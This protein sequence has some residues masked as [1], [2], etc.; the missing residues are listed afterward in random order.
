MSTQSLKPGQSVGNSDDVEYAAYAARVNARLFA[1]AHGNS[2]FT[3]DSEGLFGVYL[4]AFPDSERQFHNC[5]ACRRFI[6]RF[7]GLVTFGENGQTVSA[8]WSVDEAPDL[9]AP[10]IEAMRRVILRAKITGVFL[11]KESTYGQPLTGQW[12]HFFAKPDAASVFRHLVLS[13]D[14]AMA[15]KREDYINVSRALGEFTEPMLRQA[16]VLL[17][18]D[19]LY[20][21]EKV[22]GPAEWLHALHLQRDAVKGSGPRSN[23]VWRAVASAPAGF[24]HPRSSMV[25]TLLEDIAAGMDFESASR[26][27]AAKMHPLQYQRPQAAPSAGNI[28]QAEKIIAKMKAEGSLDRRFAKLEE[29]QAIWKPESIKPNIP[30]GGGV[31]GHLKSKAAS[32]ASMVLPEQVLTW[33]KFARSVVPDAANIEFMT[34]AAGNFS[35]LLTAMNPLAPPIIQWDR[36]NARNPVSWYLYHGGSSPESWHLQRSAWIKVNA[37]ALNPSQWFGGE[38]SHQGEG[39]IFI[40]DGAR[41]TRKSGSALFPEILRSEFHGIRSTIE[42]YSRSA[43]LAGHDEATACGYLISKGQPCNLNLRVRTKDG[44]QREYRIDRW[45]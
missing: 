7:G 20:R 22:I 35:A 24:C 45:D 14:Q 11:S 16:L 43:E 6:N 38:F 28:A 42:A 15:E 26:R 1:S 23:I 34:P 10:A 2:L 39:V 25:G 4:N 30:S 33:E 8:M 31:F 29:I 17:K 40:L 44:M 9:Y 18:S 13:P 36:E 41:D 5:Q 3:T 12:A 19:A 32:S 21:S 37:V 27:F